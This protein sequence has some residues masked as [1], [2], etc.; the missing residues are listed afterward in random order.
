MF[1]ANRGSRRGGQAFAQA[2]ALL[3]DAG[4]VIAEAK[5]FRKASDL[6]R[7]VEVAVRS[8]ARLVI[9]GGG[10][11]TQSMVAGR[12]VDHETVWGVLPLGTGNALARDL[13]LLELEHACQAMATFQT[14]RIDLGYAG[15]DY[16]VNVAT[17]G[18]TALIAE[19]LPSGA[20]KWF[21]R[22]AY[23]G[24]VIKALAKVQPM[25]A[26]LMADGHSHTIET[27][28]IVI[29]NGRFHAGPFPLSPDANIQ[30]GKLTVY[31]LEGSSK[32]AF[33]RLAWRL[34]RGHHVDLPEVLAMNVESGHLDTSPH[35]RVIIDGEKRGYTPFSF[36]LVPEAVRVVVGPNFG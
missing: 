19:N 20:K 14:A 13:D 1:Y 18:L 35:E 33:L 8:E 6:L 31:A 4:V 34:P 9:V 21:G 29:G 32:E 25:K 28:Q 12:F 27:L 16:F 10:D 30:D 36:R 17:V 26:T 11:G 3:T 23:L 24:A 22:A 5:Q 2:L 15:N 7:A